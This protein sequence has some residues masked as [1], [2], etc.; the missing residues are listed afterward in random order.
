MRTRDRNSSRRAFLQR[1]VLA[2]PG[3]LLLGRAAPART[4]ERSLS[5]RHTHTGESLDVVYFADGRYLPQ[6]LDRVNHILRD[7]RTDE[8]HP[9]DPQLLDVL[10]AARKSTASSGVYEVISGYR[11]PATNAMLR[12]KSSGGVAQRSLH[13]E[14]QAID[15]RLT[16]VD[17][18]VL[19]DT[20]RALQLGGVG[21][22]AKSDFVHLDTGGVRTW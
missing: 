10:Y 11:S 8:V 16:D 2:L 20:G 15:V 7:F 5:F 12:G 3:A 6:A 9:I 18:K 17:T 4:S 1:L 14:G 13:M 22:Y 21:Y 19:R